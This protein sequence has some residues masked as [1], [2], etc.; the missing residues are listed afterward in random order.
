M[1]RLPFHHRF[2]DSRARLVRE[3]EGADMIINQ[4]HRGRT[5]GG[6]ATWRPLIQ[7]EPNDFPHDARIWMNTAN[8]RM[9]QLRT[10]LG[11]DYPIWSELTWP[12]ESIEEFTWRDIALMSQAAL[13]ASAKDGMTD[14]RQLAAAAWAVLGDQ[15]A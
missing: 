6:R 2:R 9:D 7:Y 8:N 12:E 4:D 15:N 1:D 13:D 14:L 11:A 10:I 3:P 5:A